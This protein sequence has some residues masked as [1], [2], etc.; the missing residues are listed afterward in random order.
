MTPEISTGGGGVHPES[1]G[2]VRI[3]IRNGN[4][5]PQEALPQDERSRSFAT[6]LA[7]QS[8]R[9]IADRSVY[10]SGPSSAQEPAPNFPDSLISASPSPSPSPSPV[11]PGVAPDVLRSSHEQSGEVARFFPYG[12]PP[13]YPPPPL[14]S[15]S[16]LHIPDADLALSNATARPEN[17][18]EAP[19]RSLFEQIRD[20][21]TRV[22][23]A[24]NARAHSHN[25]ETPS[26]SLFE[27]I[28]EY[29]S[30]RKTETPMHKEDNSTGE[31]G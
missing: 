24:S 15:P 18:A 8:R 25:A 3:S 21:R 20:L 12:A 31:D 23:N 5:A 13:D 16:P 29:E 2:E 9:A 14:P 22:N 30:R 17:N 4:A 10:A 7:N 27:Q 28:R 1:G 19:G 26:L 11:T 6:E